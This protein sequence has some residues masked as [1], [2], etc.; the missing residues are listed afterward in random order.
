VHEARGHAIK[1]ALA[2]LAVVAVVRH[3]RRRRFD[4]GAIKQA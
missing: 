4:D 3:L 1:H 2:A